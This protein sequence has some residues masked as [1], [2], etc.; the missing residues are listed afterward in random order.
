MVLR[1][2][3]W[4]L[5]LGLATGIP[6]ALALARLTQTQLYQVKPYDLMVVAAAATVLCITAV[7]AGYIPA[8]RAAR[9]NP[10]I[11]LRYE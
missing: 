2:L 8:R 9:V 10:L 6:A 3:L 5:G 4:I 11:A 1:E 7:A